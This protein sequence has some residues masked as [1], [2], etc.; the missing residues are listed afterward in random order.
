MRGTWSSAP[1]MMTN[2]TVAE[3][4]EVSPVERVLRLTY[5]AGEGQGQ[6]QG[7]QLIRVPDFADIVHLESAVDRER[8][9]ARQPAVPDRAGYAS[10]ADGGRG[11]GRQGVTPPM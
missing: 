5:K 3:I 2:A 10:G 1:N 8:A 6:A 7:E 11:R 4:G 9:G